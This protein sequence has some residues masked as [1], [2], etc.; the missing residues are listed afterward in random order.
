MS[1]YICKIC[2]NTDGQPLRL[3]GGYHTS[4]CQDCVNAWHEYMNGN[5][6]H[7]ELDLIDA[8]FS[9]I[10]IESVAEVEKLA[11]KRFACVEELYKIAKKWVIN[12]TD[13]RVK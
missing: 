3:I 6:K 13:E 9:F 2:K 12:Q 7:K 4:L 11:L 8:Q 10:K 5:A 1:K